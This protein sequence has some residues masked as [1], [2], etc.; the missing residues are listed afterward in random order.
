MIRG[1]GNTPERLATEL[2][3]ET[4]DRQA[5]LF[6]NFLSLE[7]GVCAQPG[8]VPDEDGNN[9]YTSSVTAESIHHSDDTIMPPEGEIQD[10]SVDLDAAQ[11]YLK[12]TPILLN[13]PEEIIGGMPADTVLYRG[14]NGARISDSFTDYCDGEHR[15]WIVDNF[16]RP[17]STFSEP[18]VLL[19]PY[20]RDRTPYNAND[21]AAIKDH[22]YNGG[23]DYYYF[24]GC[25][26]YP[27][28]NSRSRRSELIMIDRTPDSYAKA[29]LTMFELW[30]IAG[31]KTF[32][33]RDCVVIDGLIEKEP[34]E[35]DWATSFTMYVDKETGFVVSFATYDDAGKLTD[36]S[37]YEE[38]FFDDEAEM[39]VL[40]PDQYDIFDPSYYETDK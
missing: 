4:D 31:E 12:R 9:A 2:E 7:F 20:Q 23:E 40:D 13:N 24:G 33:G 35:V 29:Y 1:M 18:G 10:F 28:Y 17:D 30:D 39:V 5:A 8:T 3:Q 32:A 37:V 14:K 11:S 21:I 26:G 6:E 34:I 27:E 25:K 19:E 36:F 15:Y 16:K 38:L 22:Y